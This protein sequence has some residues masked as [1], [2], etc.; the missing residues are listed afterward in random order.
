MERLL[1]VVLQADPAKVKAARKLRGKWSWGRARLY[2]AERGT[3]NHR[4]L[5]ENGNV[6]PEYNP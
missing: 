2:E 4:M 6:L 3:R 1:M 5:D